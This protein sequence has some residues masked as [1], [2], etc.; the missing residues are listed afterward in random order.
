MSIQAPFH[1]S[2]WRLWELRNVFTAEHGVNL[3]ASTGLQ[4]FSNSSPG[5]CWKLTCRTN[6]RGRWGFCPSLFLEL[7][8]KGG[9]IRRP[10]PFPCL[11]RERGCRM[12]QD[13][14]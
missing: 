11:P 13:A 8:H 9:E 3:E 14:G 7:M 4:H 10:F 6:Y 12:I 1:P 2:T 5:I